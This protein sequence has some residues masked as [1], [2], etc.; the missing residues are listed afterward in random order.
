LAAGQLLSPSLRAAAKQSPMPDVEIASLRL[1][2]TG[3][4]ARTAG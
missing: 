2:M 4:A 1:A 3:R